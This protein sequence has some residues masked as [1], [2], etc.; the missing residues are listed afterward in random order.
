[1]LLTSCGCTSSPPPPF[2]LLIQNAFLLIT[3]ILKVLKRINRWLSC[4]SKGASRLAFMALSNSSWYFIQQQI[5][6]S[7][8]KRVSVPEKNTG[9][10][11][12]HRVGTSSSACCFLREGFS[13]AILGRLESIALHSQTPHTFDSGSGDGSSLIR[14]AFVE[15]QQCPFP[16]D[17]QTRRKSTNHPTGHRFLA[18]QEKLSLFL[19]LWALGRL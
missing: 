7:S 3:I 13:A 5:Q 18:H 17:S 11:L 15:T 8:Y 9:V 14:Q 19:N 10:D 16:T 6:F 2:L 1:M 12:A 4:A